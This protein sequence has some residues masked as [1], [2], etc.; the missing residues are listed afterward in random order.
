MAAQLGNS[1]KSAAGAVLAILRF[2]S[3]PPPLRRSSPSMVRDV[4]AAM[5]SISFI[6]A[7]ESMADLLVGDLQQLLPAV[8]M[9]TATGP[10]R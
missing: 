10:K 1:P 3:S 5:V 6:A 2:A 9:D 8:E 7:A 4:V